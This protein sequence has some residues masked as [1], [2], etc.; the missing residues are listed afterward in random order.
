MCLLCMIAALSARTVA[1]VTEETSAAATVVVA[2]RLTIVTS[3]E[4]C[5]A[6]E[7]FCV[8]LQLQSAADAGGAAAANAAHPGYPSFL[9]R[10][11]NRKSVGI[12]EEG[13]CCL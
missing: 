9:V 12:L 10:N 1:A 13:W 11:R 2:A 5:R 7:N 4:Q 3:V 8:Q 6:K